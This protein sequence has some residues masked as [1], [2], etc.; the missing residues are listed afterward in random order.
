LTGD[1]IIKNNTVADTK[2]TNVA[3]SGQIVI[4][5]Q[6]NNIYITGTAS[7]ITQIA[8][9]W[10]G[11]EVWMVVRDAATLTFSSSDTGDLRICNDKTVSAWTPIRLFRMP[12]GFCTLVG[13]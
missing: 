7:P 8:N 6:S 10:E 3:S 9:M 5:V 4:P 12:Q 1:N 2:M 11:R 13:G